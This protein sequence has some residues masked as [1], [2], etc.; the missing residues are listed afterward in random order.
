MLACFAFLFAEAQNTELPKLTAGDYFNNFQRFTNKSP[1]VNAAFAN[2]QQLACNPAYERL[3]TE[4][5]HNSFAQDFIE[6]HIEDKT[7]LE[8]RTK[9]RLL[10]TQILAKMISDTCVI[11]RKQASPLFILTKIQEA[12]NDPKQIASLT[13]QFI[14]S[15]IDGQDIYR[16]RAG[17]YGLMI[18]GIINQY[19]ELK[20][21]KEELM[22]KLAA[23]LKAGQ[24][25][26]T[27]SSGRADLDKRAWYRFLNAY[28]NF[29][30]SEQVQDRQQKE[31]LL[32]AAFEFSP[33]LVDKNHASGY[34]YDMHMLLGKEKNGFQEEYLAFTT[35]NSDKQ[36]LMATL[37]KMALVEPSFK[38]NLKAVHQ[39]VMPGA[40]FNNYW[41]RGIDKEAV[42]S[43]PIALSVL[44]NS[45]FSSK[46]LLGQW[47]LVDFWGTW[48][49]PC[50]E[51]HPALQKFHE[52]MIADKSKKLSFLTIAC[53][54]TE[55]RV[56]AYMSK[57]N[58]NFPVAMSDK[59]IE[60]SFKIQGYPT[61][62]LIT[63]T[64]KY[65]TVP[66]GVDWVGFVNKY[67][68]AD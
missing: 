53:R 50:R 19:P 34:F 38:K 28:V 68:E 48:C 62:I 26:V 61:K 32:K 58:Y 57:N 37:L 27:D 42:N 15:E 60:K 43:P 41:Q 33:D 4:L 9:R 2:V 17:R 5:I 1:N 23:N 24:P 16:Y 6:R 66:F 46:S 12:P 59:K 56:L 29:I 11:L 47:I 54:D 52:S 8:M 31:N 67:I 25:I 40:N 45:P 55:S 49:G 64:G 51:E 39:E 44:G 22:D 14:T 3:A 13:N 65:V 18:L 36:Q 20:L 63:P 10:A 21:L 30:K 35:T 7:E